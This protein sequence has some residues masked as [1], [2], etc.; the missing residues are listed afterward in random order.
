MFNLFKKSKSD[1]LL[2]DI[3]AEVSNRE[4][5]LGMKMPVIPTPEGIKI[6]ATKIRKYTDSD[7]YKK[8]AEEA[9]AQVISDLDKILDV[10]TTKD[11]R[12]YYCGSVNAT[13]NLL[14]LSHKAKLV[15]EEWDKQQKASLQH[16]Q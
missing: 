15:L 6:D 1:S 7:G 5:V 16:N 10:K 13:L 2:A 8:F 4:E 12:D 3:L 9:W 11:Q 14:R